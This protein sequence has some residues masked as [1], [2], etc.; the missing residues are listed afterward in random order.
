M[1]GTPITVEWGDGEQTFALPI[2][3]LRELQEKTGRG[4]LALLRKV[5]A[6]EWF[7]D[8][9]REVLRLGLV[10]GGAKPP[11]ALALVKRYYDTHGGHIEHAPTAVA[12][13]AAAL[14]AP[15]GTSAPKENATGTIAP[16][17]SAT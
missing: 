12:I 4:P 5:Q 13:L 17:T 8:D 6:G 16:E 10:G 1:S 11:A 3:Q 7:V 9:L 15:K 14:T 2:D